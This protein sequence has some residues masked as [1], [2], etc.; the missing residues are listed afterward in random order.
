VFRRNIIRDTR[1]EGS[2]TQTVGFLIEE[3]AGLITIEENNIEARTPLDDRRK[4]RETTP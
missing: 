2:Q 4:T 1:D 3:T